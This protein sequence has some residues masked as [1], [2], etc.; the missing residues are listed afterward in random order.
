MSYFT[1]DNKKIYYEENGCGT[2]LLFLHGNTASS[3]MSLDDLY[4][5]YQ[6]IFLLQKH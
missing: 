2:P 1:F 5:K 4:N 6:Y 3:K